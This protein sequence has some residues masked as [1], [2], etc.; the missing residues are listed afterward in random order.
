MKAIS[1]HQ[2][3]ETRKGQTNNGKSATKG[4]FLKELR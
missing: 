2:G 1:L 3:T 4:T